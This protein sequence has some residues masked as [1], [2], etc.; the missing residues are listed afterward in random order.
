MLKKRGKKL[1]S[2]KKKNKND[3]QILL[4]F[5]VINYFWKTVD[6]KRERGK[7]L[8]FKNKNIT[9]K[10]S[11][12]ALHTSMIWCSFISQFSA[13]ISFTNG[14]KNTFKRQ[15]LNKKP[16]IIGQYFNFAYRVEV[17]SSYL[18]R[19]CCVYIFFTCFFITTWLKIT[20]NI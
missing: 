19:C 7:C 3:E 8:F 9:A 16:L 20:F 17:V 14:S 18:H 5:G 11:V 15:W 10:I 4:C 1:L 13:H 2:Q 12:W 6:V